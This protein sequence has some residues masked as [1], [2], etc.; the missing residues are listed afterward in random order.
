V[1]VADRLRASV[2][3]GDVVARFGGDEFAVLVESPIRAARR[4]RDGRPAHRRRAGASRSGID[5]PRL[6]VQASI[7]LASAGGE[8]TRRR[9]A[10]HAQRR[11]GH[12]QGQ[13]G[14]R[15]RLRQ[16]TTRRCWPAWSS[17]SSWRPTCAWP[18]SADELQLH[19]QPT[20]DLAT[21]EV[22]GFEAL[23]RWQHPTRG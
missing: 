2:R 13:V 16:R 17:G 5:D 19:Y 3:D 7:G 18:S 11:P 14:R 9:R 20:V 10:A 15:R 1:Q 22:I 12:V 8:P 21:G 6:H 23:V 4:R